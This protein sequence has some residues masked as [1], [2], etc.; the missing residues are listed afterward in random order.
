LL[1]FPNRSPEFTLTP[2]ALQA[3]FGR[4]R[5]R[6]RRDRGDVVRKKIE[7]EQFPAYK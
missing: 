3:E 6:E 2:C 7:T 4:D 1:V 5:D